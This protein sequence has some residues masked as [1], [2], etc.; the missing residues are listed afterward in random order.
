MCVCVCVCMCMYIYVYIC[1]YTP[2]PEART[3]VKK[4][5]ANRANAIR[6]QLFGLF[7][8]GANST[9]EILPGGCG[10]EKLPWKIFP[11]PRSRTINRVILPGSPDSPNPGDFP[12]RLSEARTATRT[13]LSTQNPNKSESAL[14]GAFLGLCGPAT[15]PAHGAAL[16]LLPLRYRKLC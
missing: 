5:R 13:S 9:W 6:G 4:I 16:I 10:P 2:N 12:E 15:T 3:R 7:H 1:I 8:R 14:C 11:G